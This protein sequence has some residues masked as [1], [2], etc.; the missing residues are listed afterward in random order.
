[1]QHPESQ[2][3][4][5]FGLS[6]ACWFPLNSMAQVSDKERK[7]ELDTL[8]RDVAS[9]LSEKCINPESNRPCERAGLGWRAAS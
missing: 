6:I 1:M 8:F 5:T 7:V 3:F 9:V 2:L 4:Y